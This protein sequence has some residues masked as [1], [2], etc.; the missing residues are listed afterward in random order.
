MNCKYTER[1]K[2]EKISVQ[3]SIKKISLHSFCE[4]IATGG[5]NWDAEE[6]SIAPQAKN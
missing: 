5:K 4:E 1:A 6:E 2:E 3:Y